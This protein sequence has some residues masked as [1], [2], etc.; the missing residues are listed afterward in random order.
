MKPGELEIAGWK[1]LCTPLR[2][3]DVLASEGNKFNLITRALRRIEQVTDPEGNQVSN[4]EMPAK[5][6]NTWLAAMQ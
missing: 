3:S 6:L 4:K 2:V 5:V 1:L